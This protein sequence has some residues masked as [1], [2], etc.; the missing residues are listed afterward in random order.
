[1]HAD[2]QPDYPLLYSLRGFLYCDLLLEETERAAWQ[3]L[4]GLKTEN[5]ISVS[6]LSFQ[7]FSK[8]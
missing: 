3:T 8:E 6:T 2:Q 7:I 5:L 4:L 1:M